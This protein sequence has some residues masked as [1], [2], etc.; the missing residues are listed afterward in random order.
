V[1][2]CQGDKILEVTAGKAAIAT[3]SGMKM[4]RDVLYAWGDNFFG[5]LGDGTKTNR[6][7]PTPVA[8]LDGVIAVSGGREYTV[9]LKSDRTVWTWGAN[10]SGQ[11]GDGTM[12]Q[13][14][15][16][17]AVSGLAD[18]TAI[19]AARGSHTLALKADGGVWAWGDNRLGQLGI[20]T[21]NNSPIPVSVKLPDGTP[22]AGVMALSAGSEYSVALR[23]D[24]SVWAWGLNNYGQLGDGTT[25]NRL[26]PVQVAGLADVIAVAA[27]YEH[28]VALKADGS[29][30]LWGY[31]HGGTLG[32]GVK[33]VVNQV[34]P[35]PAKLPNGSQLSGIV[36]IAAGSRHTLAL[37]GDHTVWAWGL[38]SDQMGTKCGLDG[39]L[40]QMSTQDG[41]AFSNVTAIAAGA[42][43]TVVL[44]NDR[45][46]WAC[47]KTAYGQLGD[48]KI[49]SKADSPVQVRL[50]D[51]T[52]L[53]GV[54]TIAAGGNHTVAIGEIE[55]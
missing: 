26:T 36:T 49:V 19:A 20:G 38:N 55:E 37:S 50:R 28:T 52:P 31:N 33:S 25:V 34:Q 23:N 18:V 6:A 30:W 7:Y 39:V 29:V 44:R 27:G 15:Y 42:N 16:P 17:A 40:E 35:V 1:E 21:T 22:L 48:G 8:G 3:V 14:S 4:A 53:S 54:V 46:V 11:L 10:S 32:N 13:R 51:G 41:V 9:A 45:T 2:L 47:G 12:N 43:H 5:Q 24:G